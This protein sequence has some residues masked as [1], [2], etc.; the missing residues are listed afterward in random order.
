MDR[1]SDPGPTRHSAD[2]DWA[3]ASANLLGTVFMGSDRAVG[4]RRLLLYRVRAQDC[5]ATAI[6]NRDEIRAALRA[7]FSV[8]L[9]SA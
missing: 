1:T 8:S 2:R 5:K 6:T 4:E 3:G 9:Q 7:F